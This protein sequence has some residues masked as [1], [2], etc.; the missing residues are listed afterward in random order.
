M[1]CLQVAARSSAIYNDVTDPLNSHTA[2][3]SVILLFVHSVSSLPVDQICPSSIATITTIRKMQTASARY[4]WNVVRVCHHRSIAHNEQRPVAF[5]RDLEQEQKA[6]RRGVSN[7]VQQ[8]KSKLEPPWS[9]TWR[10]LNRSIACDRALRF[11]ETYRVPDSLM[12]N[13]VK[14][15]ELVSNSAL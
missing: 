12:Q 7:R 10:R 6:R 13:Q 11:S 3:R 1:V 4:P 2:S 15:V 9:D 8:S 14:Q 5:G